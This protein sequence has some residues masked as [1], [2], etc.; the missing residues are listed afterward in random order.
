MVKFVAL[1]KKPADVEAFEKHYNEI[2]AP[3]AKKMPGLVKLEVDRD[4][5]P[6]RRFYRDL[7]FRPVSET[8]WYELRLGPA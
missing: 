4:N 6:A 3:L 8:I 5:K 1:Y 2:H 7:G